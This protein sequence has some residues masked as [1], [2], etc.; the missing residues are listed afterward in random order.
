M[1]RQEETKP[2]RK[3]SIRLRSISDINRLLGRL[4]NQLLR[5]EV[6]ESVAGKAG[7]L[8]SIML[9][10]FELSDIESRLE[11]L[12]KQMNREEER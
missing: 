9:K 5:E 3:R 8:L 4:V 12:E 6:S 7:Y 11:A 2:K 10:S 1:K